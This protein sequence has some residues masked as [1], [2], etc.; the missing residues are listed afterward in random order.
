MF[1]V[2]RGGRR[3]FHACG[4]G[5]VRA[6][7]RAAPLPWFDGHC[8]PTSHAPGK[9]LRFRAGDQADPAHERDAGPGEG[10][11]RRWVAAEGCLASVRRDGS[12]RS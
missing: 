11:A 4:A 6:P 12:R 7:G 9:S 3:E 10:S 2:V 8:N 1:V 5:S